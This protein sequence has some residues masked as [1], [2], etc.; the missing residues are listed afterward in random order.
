MG[1]SPV[2]GR[3]AHSLASAT[4][5]PKGKQ[6]EDASHVLATLGLPDELSNYSQKKTLLNPIPST[7]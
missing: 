3:L 5:D 2:L 1:S 4:V 7:D 6:A